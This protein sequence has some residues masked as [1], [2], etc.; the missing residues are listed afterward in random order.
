MKSGFTL[1]ELMIVVVIIGVL[2][3]TAA[4]LYGGYIREAAKAEANT[5]MSDIAAKEE[6]YKNSWGEYLAPIK[7]Q[8]DALGFGEK[9]AQAENSSGNQWAALGFMGNDA[10]HGGVFGGPLYFR[11]VVE[12]LSVAA[13]GTQPAYHGY[14]V[15]ACRRISSSQYEQGELRSTNRRTIVYIDELSAYNCN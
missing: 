15:R 5:V 3:A 7:A 6:V 2:A 11:Y 12:V 4:P 13:S 8:G 9:Q 1:I 10:E 14:L